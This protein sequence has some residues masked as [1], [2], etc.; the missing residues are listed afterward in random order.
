M[1]TS[2]SVPKHRIG[3]YGLS[4]NPPT[5]LG[6]HQGVVRHLAQSGRFEEIWIL[7]VYSHMYR[8]KRTMED[9]S[10]RVNMCVMMFSGESTS[11]CAVRVSELEKEVW[12]K[13][14]ECGTSDGSTVA[15][16]QHLKTKHATSNKT[17][18]LVLGS[19][20]YNDLVAGKW[21]S[22][23]EIL[24]SV[25]SLEVVLRKGYERSDAN[26]EQ[27]VVNVH[28]IPT[29]TLVSS[30]DVRQSLA[31]SNHDREKGGD[32]DEEDPDMLELHPSVAQYVLAHGLYRG[33]IYTTPVEGVGAD[34]CALGLSAFA[35]ALVVLGPVL[36]A[37]CS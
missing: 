27:V 13:Q 37:L 34:A 21:K 10:H 18:H 2:S 9:F 12:E 17:W 24:A 36:G 29:L 26:G 35:L 11:T 3:L 6:G 23:A 19:D 8:S 30:T 1:S 33:A 25:D 7:P 32:K 14:Q 22:S 15:L 28:A 16:L 5:G 20:T 4:A 31:Q